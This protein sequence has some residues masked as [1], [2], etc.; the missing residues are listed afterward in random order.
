M[1]KNK[2]IVI[3]GA[4]PCG[5]S[6]AWKLSEAGFSVQ[7]IEAENQVGGLCRTIR[8]NDF[9]FD[10][11]GHRFI[12]KD[13]QIQ[14]EIEDLMREDLLV[15]PRK[16]VIRLQGKYFNYPLD[17]KDIITKLNP[18]FT[19]RAFTDYSLTSLL[20]KLF[21]RPDSSFESWV[22]NRFGITLYNMYFDLYSKKLWG[23]PPNMISSAWADQ[24]ISLINLWDV[25]MR[26][27][28][29]KRDE[30]KTYAGRFYYPKKGIGQICEKMA[31]IITENGGK[32]Y[33]NTK[34]EHI[35]VHNN[36]LVDVLCFKEGS[37]LKIK[38]DYFISTIALPDFI[39]AIR[40]RVNEKLHA[41]ADKM[42]FRSIRFLH[43]L[44]DKE[45]ITDNTWI[46][47][48]ESMFIFFRIQ[49]I[50][51]WS[52]T[53]VPDG[54]T[55]LTLEIAC[56]EDDEIWQADDKY[57]LDICIENLKEL[58]LLDNR[59][60]ILDYFS[61]KVKHCYPMYTL[62][63]FYKTDALLDFVAQ[64]KNALS[65]GRQGLYRYNNIDHTVKMGLLAAQHIIEDYPKEEIFKV[66]TEKKI[67]DWQDPGR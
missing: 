65:V 55:G 59:N 14:K 3:L 51:N 63:Y 10:L 2:K 39:R 25:F 40:P 61:T 48:P 9:C 16:S 23:I 49:E 15:R 67:F 27:L 8:K 43:L 13:E 57:L 29:K 5:L 4:G 38:G 58:G 1:E 62:D 30:P 36:A 31:D 12:T 37:P 24:R 11:G 28:G 35:T 42:D 53:A 20:Q 64:I 22:I 21:P 32:I 44:I 66:A 50:R 60:L 56:N 33:L 52:P 41:I 34:V 19:F 18:L 46:Y 26:L 7:V 17:I 54:K 45:R 47:I 6:L